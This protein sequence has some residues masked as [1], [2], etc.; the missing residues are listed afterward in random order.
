[1]EMSFDIDKE[2]DKIINSRKT[3]SDDFN[4]SDK[5]K[6]CLSIVNGEQHYWI[7]TEDVKEFIKQL[8]ASIEWANTGNPKIGMITMFDIDKLAGEDLC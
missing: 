3:M 8:K 4:L 5:R 6:S 7:K 2:A 1:V